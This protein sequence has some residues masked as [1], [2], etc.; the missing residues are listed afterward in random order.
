MSNVTVVRTKSEL[1]KAIESQE[2]TIAVQSASLADDVKTV[3]SA[4]SCAFAL[5]VGSAGVFATNFW[6]PLGWGSGIIGTLS[7]GS[8]ITAI[9]AIGLSTT[10][11]FAIYNDYSIKG[12]T[13]IQLAGGNNIEADLVM[14]RD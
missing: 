5:A 10:L 1:E 7:T 12:R 13:S 8:L 14:E 11:L 3:K 6:N 9:I 2:R 4:S